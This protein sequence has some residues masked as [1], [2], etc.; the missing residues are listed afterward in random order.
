MDPDTI[1]SS[2]G[3]IGL[4]AVLA[5]TYGPA[6]V[7]I[8]GGIFSTSS[9]VSDAQCTAAFGVLRPRLNVKTATLL[10]SEIEPGRIPD[11][12]AK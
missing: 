9:E 5:K 1:I 6:V 7:R 3:V 12:V 11:E 8:A 2:S 4:I 10:W